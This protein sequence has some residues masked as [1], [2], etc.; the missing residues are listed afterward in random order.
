METILISLAL[1]FFSAVTK[2]AAEPQYL[3][4]KYVAGETMVVEK[5]V[6][7]QAPKAK[8]WRDTIHTEF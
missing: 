7:V 1:S 4:V 6:Y 5:I 8:T 3:P 2:P